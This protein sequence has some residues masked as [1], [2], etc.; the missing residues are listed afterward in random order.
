MRRYRGI[1]WSLLSGA[2][3]TLTEEEIRD[4]EADLAAALSV[5]PADGEAMRAMVR[6]IGTRRARADAIADR[7]RAAALLAEQRARRIR[8]TCGDW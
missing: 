4:A 5:D 2:S 6:L 3:S 8:T 7:E 1:A